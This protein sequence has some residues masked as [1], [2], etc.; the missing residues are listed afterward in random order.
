MASFLRAFCNQIGGYP[1][2]LSSI[3]AKQ[4]VCEAFS[5]SIVAKTPKKHVFATLFGP[6]LTF[7]QAK[8]SLLLF[9]HLLSLSGPLPCNFEFNQSNTKNLR[10]VFLKKCRK[11]PK[12]SNFRRFLAQNLIFFKLNLSFLLFAHLLQFIGRLP[13]KF[14]LNRSNA[15]N[16]RSVFLK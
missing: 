16:L 9:G 4:L 5:S 11:T 13:C 8:W 7:F 12:N 1:V 10:G 14:E 15:A 6:K 2:S 3:G